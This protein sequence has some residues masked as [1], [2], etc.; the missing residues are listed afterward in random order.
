MPSAA[1]TAPTSDLVD[2]FIIGHLQH[3]LRNNEPGFKTKRALLQSEAARFDSSIDAL[4][5][6]SCLAQPFADV[7]LSGATTVEQM[8]SNLVSCRLNLDEEA[9]TMLS[10]LTEPTEQY[11]ATRT[12]LPWN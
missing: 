11:W 10:V 3:L 9:I 5:L 8:L 12:K 6:A 2:N 1:P 4:A 7:V